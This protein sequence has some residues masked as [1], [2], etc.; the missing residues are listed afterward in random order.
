MA[1]DVFIS[2]RRQGGGADARMMYDRLVNAGYTVSF[3]MDTLMNGNFNEELL[4]RVAECKNFVVLLSENCFERT[5]NG[6]KREDDWLRLEI[7]TALYNDKNIVTVMLPGF[8]FPENLPLDIDAIRNRNGPKYDLYYI[9]G[10]YDKLQKDFLIKDESQDEGKSATELEKIF[11]SQEDVSSTGHA[12]DVIDL[13]GDD[14]EFIRVEADFA[15]SGIS[16]LLP[17]AELSKID[18]IWEDA[19]LARDKGDYKAAGKAY[20]QLMDLVKLATPC[21]SEFVMRMTADGIDTRKPE[22][23]KGA[24]AKAQG[25]DVN[26]QYGIGSLYAGGLG[27]PR[28][29]AAAFRWLERAARSDHGAA[30]AAIG[31]AY[32]KGEGVEADYQESRLWLEKAAVK[33][34]PIAEEGLGWLYQNGLGVP[35]DL[36]KAVELYEV[37]SQLGNPAAKFAL[38]ELYAAGDGVKSD[39]KRAI[40]LYRAA[41]A[42]DHPI[43]LRRLAESLFADSTIEDKNEALA[44]CR[45]AVNAGDVEAIVDLGLAYEKG[46]GVDRD[47][48]KAAELYRKALAQ[49]CKSAELRLEEQNPEVQYQRGVA[50]MEGETIPR[51]FTLAREWFEKASEQGHV[52]ATCR[53]AELLQNGLGGNVDIRRAISLYEKAD[54]GGSASAAVDLGFIYFQGRKARRDLGTARAY[55][56]R[57][58]AGFEKAPEPEKW[59]AVY[60]YYRLGELYREGKGVE[61]NLLTAARLFRFAAVHGNVYA[62]HELGEMYRNGAGVRKSSI[63]SD[64]WFTEMWKV[65]NESLNPCDHWAMRT[66]G[67]ACRDG[68]GIAHD[69]QSA[70]MWWR[71][72]LE[73]ANPG[74]AAQFVNAMGYHRGLVQNADAKRVIEIYTLLADGG[75]PA[76]MDNLGLMYLF[77][78]LKI[79]I[80][81]SK[82]GVEWQL[83]AAEAGHPSAMRNISYRYMDGEGVER[84]LDKSLEWLIKAAD[85]KDE[86]AML[87]L[88]ETYMGGTRLGRDFAKAK[89]LIESVLEKNPEDVWASRFLAR[90]YRDGIGVE[91]NSELAKK[92]FLRPIGTLDRKAEADDVD[93]MHVLADS[94]QNGWGVEKN[95]KRAIKLYGKPAEAGIASSMSSLN[96]IYRFN[97]T[98]ADD[99]ATA[100]EWARKYVERQTQ[101]GGGAARGLADCCVDVGNYFR[102]GYGVD[103]DAKTAYD[104]YIKA[105]EKKSWTAMLALASMCRR[106]EVPGVRVSDADTWAKKA[107]DELRPFGENGLVDAQLALGD[108]YAMGWGVDQSYEEAVAWY[109]ESFN[110]RSWL[111]ATRLARCY[112]EGKGVGIDRPKAVVLL[113]QA[114][115][116]DEGEAL[117]WLGECYEQSKM[118]LP[119]DL[120]L[121]IE[122]Y[123]RSAAEGN[124][125]GM[126]NLGRCFENGTGVAKD[127]AKALLWLRLAAAER[128]DFWG[129]DRKAEQFLRKLTGSGVIPRF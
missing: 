99:V 35:T 61:K 84:D 7:A 89:S 68:N 51:D 45:R 38:A 105:S 76:A 109:R 17:Y 43:A 93:M 127:F 79:G 65:L 111:A 58:C 94:Y 90:I 1:Y 3:D 95:L 117:G 82:K 114:A 120:K 63:D 57:A 31:V 113:K 70:A 74:A 124:A 69:F 83:K 97:A 53:L 78:Q 55:Y 110:G 102:H 128:G 15:Y 41:A 30:Q 36:A 27:V 67:A 96:R 29:P 98:S 19:E 10:F 73:F 22:W 24:L 11:A 20:L 104:W 60:G 8:M 50:C 47:P 88:A 129:Y 44:F 18:C 56:E 26:Y 40:E 34:Y 119:Q 103:A 64:K 122:Y 14:T 28:D 4:K 77:D 100:D 115:V 123:R 107:V 86:M 108:C 71:R 91:E 72:G 106:G 33:G 5:L 12:C 121:V 87:Q 126:Y 16:R 85:A 75:D 125:C 42:D 81:D 39:T 62:C 66:A 92:W 23:F 101:E 52:D 6:C 25:G 49:G 80:Q 112:A 37:A 9:D 59:H 48:E 46:W 32:S 13:I 21:S 2:Y 54:A 116:R 118:G